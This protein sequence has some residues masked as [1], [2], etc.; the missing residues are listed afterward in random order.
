MVYRVE[1]IQGVRNLGQIPWVDASS[2][3]IYMEQWV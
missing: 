3:S 2:L 1:T